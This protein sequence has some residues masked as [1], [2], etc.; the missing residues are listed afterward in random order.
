MLLFV[1]LRLPLP[2][3]LPLSLLAR[4]LTPLLPGCLLGLHFSDAVAVHALK[5]RWE[6]ESVPQG[7]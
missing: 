2:L 7:Y 5:Y 6:D 3:V 1:L 4:T